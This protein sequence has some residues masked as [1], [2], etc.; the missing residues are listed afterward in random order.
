MSSLKEQLEQLE[1]DLAK[2][3]VTISPYHDLPFAIFRYDPQL[4]FEIR[5]E[6]RF[7][8]TR[9]SNTGKQ[10]HIISLADL[11]YESI[12]SEGGIDAIIKEE[13]ELGFTR[14]QETVGNILSDPDFT[15]ISQLLEDRLN[16]INPQNAIIFLIRAGVFAPNSYKISVLLDHMKGHTETPCILFYPGS[17][18]ENVLFFMDQFDM[19]PGSYHI[20]IYNR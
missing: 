16:N 6:I 1:T 19:P 9:L 13:I 5:K 4:E 17:V 8:A 11:Y 18:R 2:E 3:V 14:A 20:N 7:L 15:P 12:N 10:V